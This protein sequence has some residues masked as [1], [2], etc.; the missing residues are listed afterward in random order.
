MGY[1]LNNLYQKIRQT[2]SPGDELVSNKP[3]S[4]VAGESVESP[5][6][7]VVP[8]KV[9]SDLSP[10]PVAQLVAGEDYYWEGPYMVMTAKY[11]IKRGYCC[12]SG[13]RHCPYGFKRRSRKGST[14]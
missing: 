3:Q 7:E 14:D 5:R 9:A 13:C 2:V 10:T 12:E 8:N 6:E 1:F 4:P 11:L